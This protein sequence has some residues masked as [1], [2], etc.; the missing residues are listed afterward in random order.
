MFMV[1]GFLTK[2]EGISMEQFIDYYEGKH[3]P[4][5]LS[6]APTPL[7]YK[8]RYLMRDHELTKS[9]NIVDCDVMTELGFANEEAFAAWMGKLYAPGI[10]EK[11]AEDEARFL[12]R[13]RTRAYVIQEYSTAG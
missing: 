4:L 11:V 12:D 10:A 9:G 7:V 8:R 6:L 5:I 13:S 1:F 2:R 3:I